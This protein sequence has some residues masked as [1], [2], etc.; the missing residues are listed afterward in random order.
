MH[1]NRRVGEG[2]KQDVVLNDREVIPA[3]DVFH[4]LMELHHD[5][6]GGLAHVGYEKAYKTIRQKYYGI[7]KSMVR[8]INQQ[9]KKCHRQTL[10]RLDHDGNCRT[11]INE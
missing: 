2:K 8:K 3:E 11:A 6:E 1:R 4:H 7:T 9:C 10:L 5:E